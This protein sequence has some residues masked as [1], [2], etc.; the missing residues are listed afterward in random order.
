MSVFE[1]KSDILGKWSVSEG[2]LTRTMI[3]AMKLQ[4]VFRY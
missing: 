1:K 4:K 3:V 2:L